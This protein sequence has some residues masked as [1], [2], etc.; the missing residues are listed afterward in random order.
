MIIKSDIWI[1]LARAERLQKLTDSKFGLLNKW[2]QLNARSRSRTFVIRNRRVS[3][4][5]V[6]LDGNRDT[7]KRGEKIPNRLLRIKIIIITHGALKYMYSLLLSAVAVHIQYPRYLYINSVWPDHSLSLLK[8]TQFAA[9]IKRCSIHRAWC[10]HVA[11]AA[12][13]W[14]IGEQNTYFTYARAWCLRYDK[15]SPSP[16]RICVYTLTL[17]VT[18]CK[19]KFNIF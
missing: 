4:R 1:Q 8:Y 11:A 6:Q 16:G 3:G 9:K 12:A 2:F 15:W 5:I 7:L 18:H 10:W 14:A 17:H 13:A 19:I